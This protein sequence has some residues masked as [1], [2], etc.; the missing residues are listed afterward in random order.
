MRFK[1]PYIIAIAAISFFFAASE[2]H[3]YLLKEKEKFH[4]PE[5]HQSLILNYESNGSSHIDAGKCSKSFAEWIFSKGVVWHKRNTNNIFG[6]TLTN[7]GDVA[8]EGPIDEWI[9]VYQENCAKSPSDP[10]KIEFPES[11]K[12]LNKYDL[13]NKNLDE[14][15]LHLD[16]LSWLAML[17]VIPAI[18]CAFWQLA[19]VAFRAAIKAMK[20]GTND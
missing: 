5:L 19:G 16:V 4:D 18:W 7:S 2:R 13:A 12:Y 15:P 6:Y 14:F 3:L 10:I 11:H 8:S 20:S 17:F 1:Y 9:N